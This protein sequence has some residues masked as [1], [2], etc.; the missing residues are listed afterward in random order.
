MGTPWQPWS[1]PE[2]APAGVRRR[3]VARLGLG[4]G[5][6]LTGGLAA[7]APGAQ[8]GAGSSQSATGGQSGAQDGPVVFQPVPA[9]SDMAVGRTRFVLAAI[10]AAEGGGL[11]APIADGKLTVQFY[12]PITPQAVLKGEA[13]PEFRYVGDKTKGVYVANYEFDEPGLWGVQVL[14]STAEGRPLKQAGVQFQV[15]ARPDAPALGSPAPRSANPTRRDVADIKKLCSLANPNDLEMHDLSIAEAIAQKKPLVVAFTT[16]GF[17]ESRLCA[18]QLGE[19]QQLHA[20]YRGQVNFVHVEIYKD[21]LT[22]TPYETVLEWK[23]PSEPWTFFVDRDGNV[24]ERLEGPAPLVEM[25]P[26]LQKL[27]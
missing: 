7:C 16:P 24:A 20:K 8:P 11:P 21:P 26:L 3:R 25:E 10:K 18:P 1:A 2:P 15:K 19:V 13:V 12:F 17:C 4:A 14:G 22:R 6:A 9:G 23:L 5:V 27:L